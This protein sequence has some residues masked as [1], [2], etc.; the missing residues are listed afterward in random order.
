MESKAEPIVFILHFIKN[1]NKDK[2]KHK[3]SYMSY[4]IGHQKDYYKDKVDK[5]P[6]DFTTDWNI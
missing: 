4:S 1:N 3:K 2:P 6:S 5:K